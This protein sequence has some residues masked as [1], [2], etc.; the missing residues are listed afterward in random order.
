MSVQTLSRGHDDE[1]KP[2][3]MREVFI[4]GKRCLDNGSVVIGLALALQPRPPEMTRDGIAIQAALLEAK[5]AQPRPR[6][7]RALGA[8]IN[9]C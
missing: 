5:T 6:V 1:G 7:L 8:F 4:G 3:G 2:M 9:W